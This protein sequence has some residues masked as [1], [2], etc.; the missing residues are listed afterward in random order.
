MLVK[1]TGICGKPYYV[2]PLHVEFVYEAVTDHPGKTKIGLASGK[3]Y[4][5]EEDVE[6]V[7]WALFAGSVS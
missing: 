7:Q 4:Y 3:S 2:N 1:F 5:V 6:K